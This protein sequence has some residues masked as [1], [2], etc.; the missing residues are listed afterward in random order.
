MSKNKNIFYTAPCATQPYQ[1][2]NGD[3]YCA[4]TLKDTLTWYEAEEECKIRG[5]QLPEI[6]N[7][8]ENTN[9]LKLKV[10]LFS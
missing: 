10:W 6:H 4:F 9:I 2:A 8:E 1:K 7:I 3:F 5:G